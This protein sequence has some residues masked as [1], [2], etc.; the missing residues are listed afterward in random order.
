MTLRTLPEKDAGGI[1]NGQKLADPRTA[2]NH[3]GGGGRLYVHIGCLRSAPGVLT[4][5]DLHKSYRL[6]DGTVQALR[7]ADLSIADPGF[8]AIMGASGSGK[9]TLLYL[10]ATLDRPDR[11]TIELAGR[12]AR[13]VQ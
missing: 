12:R 11:G 13:P 9:S 2:M 1:F 4:C 6:G 7:G 3:A 10:L 8:Y 5:T